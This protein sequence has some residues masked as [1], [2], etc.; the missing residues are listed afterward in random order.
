MSDAQALLVW[1]CEQLGL[2]PVKEYRFHPTRLWR[3][4]VA[5]PEQRVA[6]EI[7]G[8]VWSGGRHV[9]G[10]GYIAD[11]EKLAEA[12]ILG[13]RVLRVPTQWVTSGAAL[14]LIERA[15]GRDDDQDEYCAQ[16]GRG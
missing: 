13:W 10:A 3:F 11:C 15:L 14:R 9:R 4:D 5:F 8:G 1:Q 6:V 12:A 7:D 16:E 2:K